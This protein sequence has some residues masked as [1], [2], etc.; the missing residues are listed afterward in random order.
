MPQDDLIA[1][2]PTTQFLLVHTIS[3]EQVH[4]MLVNTTTFCFAQR[5]NGAVVMIWP[6]GGESTLAES[7]DWLVEQLR[8]LGQASPPVDTNT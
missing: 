3:G 8:P 1:V 7:W 6:D 2:R 5:A 4:P